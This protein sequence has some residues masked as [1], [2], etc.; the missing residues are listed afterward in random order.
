MNV[1]A[2]KNDPKLCQPIDK[3]GPLVEMA[4]KNFQSCYQHHGEVVIDEA[5]KGIYIV[6][7][8]KL[9]PIYICKVTKFNLSH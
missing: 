6:N 8:F 3:V 2:E 9:N 1:D 7:P 5:M 4:R